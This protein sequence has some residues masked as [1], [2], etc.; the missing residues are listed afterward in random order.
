MGVR[1]SV[2]QPNGDGGGGGARHRGGRRDAASGAPPYHRAA[3][4]GDSGTARRKGG[5]WGCRR[6]VGHRWRRCQIIGGG[7]SGAVAA[8]TGARKRSAVGRGL[9]VGSGEARWRGHCLSHRQSVGG[10]QDGGAA[11]T[12]EG[13]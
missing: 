13:W 1:P 10:G 11:N 8:I 12:G 6:I 4:D 2:C 7:L 9:M 5:G 3:V